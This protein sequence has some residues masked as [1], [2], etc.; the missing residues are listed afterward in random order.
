VP[1]E[2]KPSGKR[3]K[4][5]LFST[6]KPRTAENIPEGMDSGTWENGV[7]GT[8]QKGWQKVSV[9]L[10]PK[11]AWSRHD[12]WIHPTTSAADLKAVMCERAGMQSGQTCLFGMTSQ[13]KLPFE[14]T[15]LV[16]TSE[17]WAP[18]EHRV[19]V[20]TSMRSVQQPVS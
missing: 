3:F 9:V 11:E 17:N 10:A 15:V 5:R 1:D 7:S 16:A 19:L 12:V 18:I 4:G 20:P 14:K 8:F 2:A 13:V 6:Q